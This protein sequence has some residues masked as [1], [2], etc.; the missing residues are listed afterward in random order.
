MK[1]TKE[2]TMKILTTIKNDF[3][4]PYNVRV[5]QQMW[6][7]LKWVMLIAVS[8]LLCIVELIDH[9]LIAFLLAYVAAGLASLA[10][11]LGILYLLVRFVKWAWTN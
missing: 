2:N 9:P 8:A 5:A 7:W 4:T 11:S 3:I 1:S 6:K 10:V